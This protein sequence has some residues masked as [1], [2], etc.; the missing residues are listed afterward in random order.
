M[1]AAAGVGVLL[2]YGIRPLQEA[3][4]AAGKGKATPTQQKMLFTFI[5]AL[6]EKDG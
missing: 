3:M 2:A 5:Q 6:V 1:S 4:A